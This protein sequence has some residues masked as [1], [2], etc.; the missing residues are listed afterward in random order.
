MRADTRNTDQAWL[1]QLAFHGVL[2]FVF[3]LVGQWRVVWACRNEE[4]GCFEFWKRRGFSQPAR[5]RADDSVISKYSGSPLFGG[6]CDNRG[7][8]RGASVTITE[9]PWPRLCAEREGT[10]HV[11]GNGNYWSCPSSCRQP[12]VKKAP[13]D[14][15]RSRTREGRRHSIG[16]LGLTNNE[17]ALYISPRMDALCRLAIPCHALPCLALPCVSLHAGRLRCFADEWL[18]HAGFNQ[19]LSQVNCGA[20]ALRASLLGAK[21]DCTVV[22]LDYLPNCL[23]TYVTVI[24][25]SLFDYGM[26]FFRCID[27]ATINYKPK[28]GPA[29]ISI[30]ISVSISISNGI[31]RPAFCY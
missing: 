24:L 29:N 30:S 5:S 25:F 7:S 26:F 14:F 15:V 20:V 23:P 22:M 16:L 6:S 21:M 1:G 8:I 2:S 27:S 17:T 18:I 28:G 9:T 10:I 4:A 13:K 3:H 19:C 12:V 31:S 11:C